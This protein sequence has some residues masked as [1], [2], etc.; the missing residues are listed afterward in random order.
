[1]KAYHILK[2]IKKIA[3]SAAVILAASSC[4]D[5]DS[6]F[7]LR[8]TDY[9]SFDYTASSNTFTV[10][11]NGDWS[12]NNDGNEWISLEPT[13]GRGDGIAYEH[14]TVKVDRNGGQERKGRVL[15]RAAGK[16]IH[17]DVEQK[18]GPVVAFG[19]PSLKG[20][21]L[22]QNIDVGET[23]LSIPYTNAI[24]DETFTLSVSADGA[25]GGINA[26]TNHSVTLSDREGNIE[27][28]LSGKPTGEGAVTFKIT[29]SYTSLHPSV[30]IP[31]LE[32]TV[33]PPLDIL[34]GAPSFSSS[35][36]LVATKRISNLVLNIPYT[37]GKIGLNFTLS[38]LVSGVSGIN[39]VNDY[40]VTVTSETGTITIPITGAPYHAGEA[41]FSFIYPGPALTPLTLPV[42]NDGKKYY[43]GTILVTGAMPDPR[44]NDCNTTMS[45]SWY[46]P[47][48]DANVHGDGYE[49]VQLMAVEDIDFS[50]TPYSVV[51][52][53]TTTAQT[54]AEKGWAEGKARTYK[55]NLTEGKVSRGEFFYIGGAAKA[56]NGYSS[57]ATNV[58]AS[59]YDGKVKDK[60][61][62]GYP[63]AIPSWAPQKAGTTQTTGGIISMKESK[64]IRTKAYRTEDGDGF[65][66]A[67][68]GNNSNIL[69]NCPNPGSFPG[70]YGVDGIAVYKGTEVYENTIPMDVVFFGHSSAG[71]ANYVA[72]N[73]G[74]TVPLNDLYSPVNLSSGEA[75]PYFG[76]GAN[77]QFLSAGQPELTMGI[78]CSV[79][80]GV[81]NGRDCG[82]FIKFAGELGAD[83]SWI[84]PREP[85]TVYLLE[86]KF[87]LEQYGLARPAQISD[88]ESN[89]TE[90]G[91]NGPVMIIH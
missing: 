84:K 35:A 10:R 85:K 15:L 82:T 41:V 19:T 47:N 32:T 14:V 33:Y 36:T 6:P 69:S 23:K 55:F 38:V 22:Q 18:I 20:G 59:S 9:L 3:A 64:W 89:L 50:V 25:S 63:V 27:V 71:A 26:I 16:E 40:P 43:P 31:N 90:A 42:I 24:G 91:A 83:N 76:Q 7:V 11:T 74:Y 5:D 87:H 45:V 54:P 80:S 52:S 58:T 72:N 51:I 56:L 21:V 28:P 61:W 8:D 67:T 75:Q 86:P 37:Q 30:T 48:E 78:P 2:H 39:G 13:S 53:K 68:S 44:G 17:I 4:S 66:A 49:Y 79:A 62:T 46:N 57:N 88:I 34:L 70:T 81:A 12:V 60:L 77:T 65:G 73:M 29:T 1:M